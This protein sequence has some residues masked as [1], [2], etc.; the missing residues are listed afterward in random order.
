[1]VT[2]IQPVR[3]AGLLMLAVGLILSV[4]GA[5][6][7]VTQFRR[8]ES[9]HAATAR[10]VRSFADENGVH[11]EFWF[12]LNGSSFTRPYSSTRGSQ[13]QIRERAAVHIA[14]DMA[15]VYYDPKDP[16]QIDPNLGYNASTLSE[17][18]I[19]LGAGVASVLTGA[20]LLLLARSAAS[21]L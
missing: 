14:G 16:N 10:V 8:I 7:L 2:R 21:A 9:W 1:M 18:A 3:L 20:A 11:Y 15:T 17:A 6:M 12:D 19:A 5:V 13:S 4:A